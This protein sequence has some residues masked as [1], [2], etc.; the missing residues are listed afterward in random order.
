MT[1]DKWDRSICADFG[2]HSMSRLEDRIS[3]V[4]GSNQYLFFADIHNQTAVPDILSKPGILAALK[5]AGHE[6]IGSEIFNIGQNQIFEAYEQGL[7]SDET[8]KHYITNLPTNLEGD[9]GVKDPTEIMESYFEILRNAK[10]AGIEFRGLAALEGFGDREEIV[11]M[12]E[13]AGAMDL[14]ILL[15][16]EQSP[17]YTDAPPEVRAAAVEQYAREQLGLSA[18]NIEA[19]Q[20][21]LGNVEPESTE[22]GYTNEIFIARLDADVV[23]AEAIAEMADGKP[24]TIIYGGLHMWRIQGDL[25]ASLGEENTAVISAFENSREFWQDMLPQIQREIRELGIDS[26]LENAGDYQF[27]MSTNTWYDSTNDTNTVVAVPEGL[28]PD[29]AEVIPGPLVLP[30]L[31]IK[32]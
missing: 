21:R 22:A 27:D 26:N 32:T 28:G 1:A 17:G 5:C 10:E 6:K 25:D 7:I 29:P 8:M 20:V 11:P 16:I 31:E 23:Q 19:L 18:E 14:A 24:M 30:T 9:M 12:L 13:E 2:A 4:A 15:A 3:A